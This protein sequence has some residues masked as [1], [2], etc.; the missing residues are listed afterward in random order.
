MQVAARCDRT[1]SHPPRAAT[2]QIALDLLYGYRTL[3]Q[4]SSAAE[5]SVHLLYY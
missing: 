4:Y 5:V 3:R 1:T 2:A